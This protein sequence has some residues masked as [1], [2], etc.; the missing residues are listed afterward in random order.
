MTWSFTAGDDHDNRHLSYLVATPIAS[1]EPRLP[2]HVPH[3][4][5]KHGRCHQHHGSDVHEVQRHAQPLRRTFGGQSVAGRAQATDKA[6]RERHEVQDSPLH[7]SMQRHSGPFLFCYVRS[8]FVVVYHASSAFSCISDIVIRCAMAGPL[9]QR[10]MHVQQSKCC[11][12]Y[13]SMVRVI[14]C[15]SVL[16]CLCDILAQQRDTMSKVQCN[17]HMKCCVCVAPGSMDTT[18]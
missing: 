15:I 17:Q 2:C 12:V 18:T 6:Q 8:F 3:V 11:Y 1:H 10:A 4:E 13:S 16:T 5:P 9:M 14:V 7:C